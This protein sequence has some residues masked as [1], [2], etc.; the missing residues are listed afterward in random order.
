MGGY[1]I[2]NDLRKRLEE[3]KFPRYIGF[4]NTKPKHSK[5]HS[6]KPHKNHSKHHGLKTSRPQ[7]ASQEARRSQEA[8]QEIRW[9]QASRLQ[10]AQSQKASATIPFSNYAGTPNALGTDAKPRR[11][12]IRRRSRH[13]SYDAWRR[14][15]HAS[16]DARR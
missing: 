1:R 11:R 3:E 10:K 6:K 15:R 8:S 4:L 2:K 16:H 5:K 7:K 12:R 14:I 13:A 9:S